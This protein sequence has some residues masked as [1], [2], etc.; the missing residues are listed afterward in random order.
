MAKFVEGAKIYGKDW[1]KI[2]QYVGT[3][4]LLSVTRYWY[5]L[6]KQIQDDPSLDEDDLVGLLEDNVG[7]KYWS[8]IQRR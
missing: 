1:D 6:K 3:R 8:K 5:G 2:S 7:E 4:S